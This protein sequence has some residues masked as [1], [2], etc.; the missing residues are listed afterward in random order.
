MEQLTALDKFILNT[1]ILL[2]L[3]TTRDTSQDVEDT[4]GRMVKGPCVTLDSMS[5]VN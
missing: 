3:R 2:D 1:H 4:Q 5:I